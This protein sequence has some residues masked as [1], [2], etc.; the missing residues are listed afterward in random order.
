MPE[1]SRYL[2]PRLDNIAFGREVVGNPLLSS[3]LE[4]LV[5]NGMGGYASGTV[6]GILTR[7]YHGLL[8]ASLNQT[9][10][11]MLLVA[12]LDEE[13]VY[14]GE[15]Y[16]LAANRWKSGE[17]APEGYQ[18]IE[19][20]YFD[21]AI[22]VWH[23][24]C[25]DLLLEKRIFMEQGQ[26]TTYTRYKVL[27]ASETLKIKIS[28]LVNYRSFHAS[29]R[30]TNW[31][32][33]VVATQNGMEIKPYEKATPFYLFS[34]K[35]EAIS[36]HEWYYDYFLEKEAGRSL[37][38]VEDHL[39]AGAFHITLKAGESC[40]IVATTEKS[41][42]LDGGEAL[43]RRFDY[44]VSLVAR[45]IIAHDALPFWIKQLHLAADQ[46]I[47]DCKKDGESKSKTI[48]AG[49]HWFDD[50][51]RD[52]MISLSGLTLTTGR[53]EDAKAI[54]KTFK[55]YVS[56]GM[57]PNQSGDGGSPY[58]GSV[59]TALWY[60]EAARA[61]YE[62]TLDRGIVEEL[63]PVFKE[64][65]GWYEKGSR[66]EIK[67]D[68][69]DGLLKAGEPGIQLTW[70]DAKV[71]GDPVTARTGK[72]IEINALWYAALKTVS[73]FASL[74]G[75]DASK[76]DQLKERVQQN[77]HKFWNPDAGYCFDVIEGPNGNESSL[78]PNQLFAISLGDL[79][80]KEQERLV[81]E[82]SMRKLLTS[83][84]LRTLN[85]DNFNYHGQYEGSQTE[86]ERSYH[87]GSVWAF[88][89]GP[90]CLAHFKVY[91]DKEASLNILSAI[92]YHLLG[93][94]LGTISEIFD[95]DP[96]MLPRGCI[97]QAWSV[98]QVLEAY[99]LITKS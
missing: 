54:L 32:M 23:I 77:F 72:A 94:G 49:Y 89:L 53:T 10:Q 98:A 33:S 84:G 79:L 46:F 6:S 17:I 66:H 1:E 3:N 39:F 25:G 42:L 24:A 35:G 68:P 47:V 65:I 37:D 44:E 74:L 7:R 93:S 76:F 91:K 67:V 4:W 9:L 83:H 78:R 60:I 16:S 57:L 92:A 11:R 28:A 19:C 14:D 81:V 73:S 27:R 21:G 5:T 59:D 20:F 71:G 70:M 36:S 40:T 18:H 85:P 80:L 96:P 95:G 22:P 51:S 48:I 56:Q 75:Q 2:K 8:I 69:Q 13:V 97:A 12:K 34:D 30:G 61:F 58:Y 43:K 38:S 29:T 45:S 86:R 90:F 26:N 41:P 87:Q 82:I 99:H 62:A 55:R 88:L 63:F 50:W 15:S 64:I 31:R 52:T